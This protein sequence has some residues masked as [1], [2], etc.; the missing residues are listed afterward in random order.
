MSKQVKSFRNDGR[1]TATGL[2]NFAKAYI[3]AADHV[4]KLKLSFS[5]PAY[6]LYAHGI[7]L[8]LKA[9]LRAHDA[10]LEELQRL[11]HNLPALLACA[12]SWGL[13]EGPF[14]DAN[15]L[16]VERLYEY[17]RHHEFRYISTGYK[18]LPTTDD[19]HALGERLL[20][21]TQSTASRGR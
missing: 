7:E 13:N 9:F 3:I 14:A 1:T 6:F 11:D 4:A 10:S 16:L 2:W 21:T 8:V 15:K 12:R 5:D 18:S 20:D 17:N 19:L